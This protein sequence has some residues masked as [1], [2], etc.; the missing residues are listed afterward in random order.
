MNNSPL[1]LFFLQIIP[2]IIMKKTFEDALIGRRSYYNLSNESPVV[3]YEIVHVLHQVVK[4]VPSAF[5]SQT[6]RLVLLLGEEHAKLWNIVR[7]TLKEI[8][9]EDVFVKT[10]EKI[11]RSFASGYGTVLFWEDT[12][13]VNKFMAS[14]PLYAENFKIWSQQ[15]SGMHQFAVWTMLEDLGFGASLQHYNPLIDDEVKRMWHLP[16]EWTL[17]A[18]MPF[19]MPTSAPDEK[20][21][22]P[23]EDRVKVFK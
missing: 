11:N 1:P 22:N 14:Y 9:P 5:N 4:H 7:H 15:T 12:E 20:I 17:V 8:V 16:K 21:F 13:V 10:E 3:D 18:Q 6:T 23:L 2:Y 19:G